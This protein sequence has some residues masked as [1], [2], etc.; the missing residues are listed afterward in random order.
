[1]WARCDARGQ[2]L[3]IDLEAFAQALRQCGVERPG[4]HQRAMRARGF[5][6]HDGEDV[7]VERL[8]R[9]DAFGAAEF[10]AATADGLDGVAACIRDR[11][12]GKIENVLDHSDRANGIGLASGIQNARGF[13]QIRGAAR[14][15]A[16]RVQARG[17]GHRAGNGTAP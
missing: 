15:D 11:R 6:L 16:D 10:D 8:D 12:L 9:G 7:R 17:E 14:E 4:L 5:R 3:V 13:L 1:M 2:R